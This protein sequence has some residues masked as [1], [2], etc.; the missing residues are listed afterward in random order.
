M[1]TWQYLW[2]LIAF[3]PGLYLF[4][5]LCW[6]TVNL[7]PLLTGLVVRQIFDVLTGSAQASL[8]IGGLLAL[9]IGMTIG[10]IGLNFVGDAGHVFF[11]MAVSSLLQRNLFWHILHRPGRKP[12]PVQPAKR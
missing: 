6:I 5:A 9:L 4:F 12:C 1:K 3:R 8:T 2:R 10:E 11:R 7:I